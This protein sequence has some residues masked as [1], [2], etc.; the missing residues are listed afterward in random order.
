MTLSIDLIPSDY[1]QR[2]R[3]HGLLRMSLAL[4]AAVLAMTAAGGYGLE[5]AAYSVR[6][7]TEQARLKL[8]MNAQQRDQLDRLDRQLASLNDELTLLRGLRSGAAAED[9]FRIIDRSLPGNDV[10]FTDWQFRRAGVLVP[11]TPGTVK[12]GYFIVVRPDTEADEQTPWQ[13]ETHMKIDGQ[14]R[15][16]AALSKFVRGLFEQP[17]IKDVKL[18]RTQI[19]RY[20]NL[21]VVDFDLAVVLHSRSAS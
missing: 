17:E 21:S 6:Q 11:E 18:N 9:L 13:V 10:W 1:R 8:A 19:R 20:S 5:R 4:A 12:T 14:A 7:D 15:D 3:M 2:L 16:H